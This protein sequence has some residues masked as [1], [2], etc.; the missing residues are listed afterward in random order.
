MQ[1]GATVQFHG[2]ESQTPAPLGRWPTSPRPM[3]IGFIMPISDLSAFGGTPRFRDML[4]MTQTAEALGYDAVWI[5]DHFIVQQ[6]SGTI[7]GVWEGWTTVAG[8]AAATS[9]ITIGIFV[10]CLGWRH[11][12]IVAK[13]AEN[14]DEISNGRFVLGVGAGWHKPEYDMFGFPF[15]HR[16]DRFE[17]AIEIINPLLR[18]GRADAT[19]PYFEVH[20]AVNLPR[21]PRGAEGG[22]IIL[23]GTD[24]PRMMR[25]TAKYAD[26]WNSSW[27]R[28]PGTLVPLL[29]QLDQACHEVGRDP[30]TLIRTAGTNVAMPGYLGVRPN[31]IQGTPK[32]MAEI[33]QSFR[34]HGL[35]HWVAGLD[36]CTPRSL[37]QFA[38]VIEVFDRG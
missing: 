1:T 22:P 11:P 20:Q 24:G 19:G 8:L 28:E 25:L 12:G 13:M 31:P 21:G 30:A 17:N 5:P 38:R 14:V 33:L 23:V 32:Q 35:R 27:H 34:A 6:D 15:D 29:E 7:R 16:V 4:E 26:A 2:P 18:E 10:T 9:R 37:E 36:P 3:G